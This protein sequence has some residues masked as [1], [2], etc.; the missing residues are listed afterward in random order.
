MKN[1]FFVIVW[2][3]EEGQKL[4]FENEEMGLIDPVT[5]TTIREARGY[6]SPDLKNAMKYR[7][8][9]RAEMI[10]SAY[11]GAVVEI[12]ASGERLK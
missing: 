2:M 12:I 9:W 10:A 8:K 5:K 4:Y 11:Q 7:D 3:N 1:K 6:F